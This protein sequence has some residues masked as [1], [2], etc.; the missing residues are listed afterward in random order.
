MLST[1]QVDRADPH[2]FGSRAGREHDRVAFEDLTIRKPDR[3][4]R[5]RRRICSHG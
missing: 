4:D 2:G 3:S 5:Y 1:E